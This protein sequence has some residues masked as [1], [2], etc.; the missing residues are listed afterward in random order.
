MYSIGFDNKKEYKLFVQRLKFFKFL[1]DISITVFTFVSFFF[2]ITLSFLVFN[3]IQSIFF[4]IL[5]A[6]FHWFWAN[7]SFCIQLYSFLFY[8]MS[9]YYFKTR[10]QLLNNKISRNSKLSVT[11]LTA[12]IIRE[13]N[14]IC[15]DILKY[16]KFWKNFYFALTYTIK[17]TNLMLLQ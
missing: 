10:F 4:G 7:Y 5:N 9:C 12:R 11:K 14:N 17:P 6:M 1:I 3:T 15:N 2:L 8:F 13:H 16:D